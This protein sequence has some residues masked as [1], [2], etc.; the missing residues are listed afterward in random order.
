VDFAQS[1]SRPVLM[2]SW[3]DFAV[4]PVLMAILPIFAN[5]DCLFVNFLRIFI[6]LSANFGHTTILAVFRWNNF[7]GAIE[8]PPF[9]R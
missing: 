8:F 7:L 3:V 9:F 5:E 2:F 4:W 1:M 6:M